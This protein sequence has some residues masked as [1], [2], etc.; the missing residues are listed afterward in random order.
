MPPLSEFF[1][2]VTNMRPD[3]CLR[4]YPEE[5]CLG[6]AKVPLETASFRAAISKIRLPCIRFSSFRKS[7][8]LGIVEKSS[9]AVQRASPRNRS[10][11]ANR[12][13]ATLVLNVKRDSKQR[14][15]Q[16]A[17]LVPWHHLAE[18]AAAFTAWHVIM[19]WVRAISE[20]ANQ[21]PA[22]VRSFLQ[23]RCPG[24]L[25]GLTREEK[26][27]LPIW[28][29]LEDWVVHH[30]FAKAITE[31]RFGAL[32]YY[33]YKDL[34]TEQAW[35]TWERTNG[36]WRNSP[37][38]EW[39]TMEEWTAEILATRTLAH[40]GTEKVRAV[41]ALARVEVGRFDIAVADLLESRALAL[42]V[43]SVSE[44]AQRLTAAV[45]TEL[46]N[47]CPDLFASRFEARW[48]PSLFY[49][50]ARLGDSKWRAVARSE[51]WYSALCYQVLHH[52]RYQRLIHYNQRCHDEWSL[53]R[54]NPY[55]SF[56]E[57]LEAADGYRAGRKS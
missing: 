7:S 14:A 25:E 55:P 44:P 10:S 27:N 30:S 56:S 11:M 13:S 36:D 50:L 57:W 45:L 31:G 17:L 3:Q 23:S 43:D 8:G 47:R 18:G 28:K 29:S 53:A 33:A 35:T 54:Q 24:F 41:Q 46:N 4:P 16:E 26:D 32:M 34:R 12:D 15:M 40:G 37:P 19:L 42:W 20:T 6:F 2:L 51:G 22:I 9:P 49:R 48:V 38:Q 21:L 39:P 5:K 52:P 1:H